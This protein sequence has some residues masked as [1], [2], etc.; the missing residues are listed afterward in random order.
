MTCLG[1]E[2]SQKLLEVTEDQNTRH[3]LELKIKALFVT[4]Y[5]VIEPRI[6]T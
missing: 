4:Y 6:S 1:R 3:D 5:Q 2:S